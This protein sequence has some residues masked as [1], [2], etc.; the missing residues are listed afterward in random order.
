MRFKLLHSN[1]L[2]LANVNVDMKEGMVRAG[3][4]WCDRFIHTPVEL[5][6]TEEI[7]GAVFRVEI[8]QSLRGLKAAT[9]L[10]FKDDTVDFRLARS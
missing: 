10:G 3:W 7:E 5:L 8:R 6:T 9:T 1:R 4:M 2:F